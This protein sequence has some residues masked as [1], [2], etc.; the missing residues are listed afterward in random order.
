[1]NRKGKKGK[2]LSLSAKQSLMGYG[3]IAVWIVGFLGFTLYPTIYSIA[4]S[5][6]RVQLT[7]SGMKLSWSGLFFYDYTLNTDLYFKPALAE[8]L[9]FICCATP[10][11]VV[12]ALIIAMLLNGKFPLRTF[13]RGVFFLPVIVMSGPVIS[14]LLAGNT[15]DLSTQAPLIESFL[16]S[17]PDFIQ[18]PAQFILNNLVMILWFSG[19]QILVFLAGLQKISP[20][21]Y[22]AADIDGAGAWE[23]FWKITMPHVAPLALLCAVYTIVDLA[24]SSELEV[25]KLISDRIFDQTRLYSF[26]AAMSWIYSI[27]IMLLLGAVYL[28]FALMG[29]RGKR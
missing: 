9:M 26:S 4:M 22:E 28:L 12:F 13:F 24:N 23:K 5:L 16:K 21:I 20:D 7:T 17:L 8:D 14:K 11:I 15:V 3:F 19:V 27:I 1:M 18:S 10:V 25:N 6:S 2:A 29:R